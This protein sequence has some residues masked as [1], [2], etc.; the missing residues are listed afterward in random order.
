[1]PK[2]YRTIEQLMGVQYASSQIYFERTPHGLFRRWRESKLEPRVF[3]LGRLQDEL[4]IDTAAPNNPDA[5]NIVIA[6][7]IPGIALV[8]QNF[9]RAIDVSDPER[10]IGFVQEL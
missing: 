3:P 6:P 7:Q 8:I 5:A 10:L 9:R 4:G 2:G 1:L